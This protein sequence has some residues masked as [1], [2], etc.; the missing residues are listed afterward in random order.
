[1]KTSSG[2]IAAKK[3]FLGWLVQAGLV[4]SGPLWDTTLM[5]GFWPFSFRKRFIVDLV[6]GCHIQRLLEILSSFLFFFL[7][8]NWHTEVL[9]L[10]VD[11]E[12]QLLA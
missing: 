8:S 3:N 1:M 7:G 10:G 11:S 9:E 5:M 12:L 2:S 4:A 6:K